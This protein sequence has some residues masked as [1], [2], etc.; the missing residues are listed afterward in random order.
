MHSVRPGALPD[1]V[2]V[3]SMQRLSP[4]ISAIIIRRAC[5]PGMRARLILLVQRQHG[6]HRLRDRPVSARQFQHRLQ[7]VR[8]WNRPAPIRAGGVRRLPRW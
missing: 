2:R 7:R 8:S 5:L 6:M 3:H 4:W 1:G